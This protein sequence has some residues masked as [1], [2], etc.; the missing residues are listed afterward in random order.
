MVDFSKL[1]AMSPEERERNRA[2]SERRLIEKDLADRA[3]AATDLRRLELTEDPDVR[4]GRDGIPFAVLRSERDGSSYSSI[5]RPVTGE[6]ERSFVRRLSEM[7]KGEEFIAH[8]HEETRSWKD[9]GGSWRSSVEF[10][11]DV[12]LSPEKLRHELPEGMT[13][14]QSAYARKQAELAERQRG[15]SSGF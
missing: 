2:E 4:Y 1:M 7:E 8:G 11:I 13:F 3:S 10:Q 12:P 15:M 6:D 14:P 5:T 9:Q